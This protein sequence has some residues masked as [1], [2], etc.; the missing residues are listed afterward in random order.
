MD[1]AEKQRRGFAI[2]EE[3]HRICEKHNISYRLDSGTLLGAIR[4][5]GFI[6]WDDD[7]DLCFLREEWEKFEKAAKEELSEN[8]RRSSPL[9]HALYQSTVFSTASFTV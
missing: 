8:F 2:L 7:V 4:H 1:L 6:P 9:C 5:E 3:I